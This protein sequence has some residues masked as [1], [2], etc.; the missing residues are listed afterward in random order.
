[1]IGSTL[2]LVGVDVQNGDY[3]ANSSSCSMCKRLV[4]NA[5][6]KNVI[7]RDDKENYRVVDVQ[8][9]VNNDESLEGI[10]GY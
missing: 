2:Y 7:I 5:G 10:L 1:M 9:W 4:I 8:D 6:I 3:V